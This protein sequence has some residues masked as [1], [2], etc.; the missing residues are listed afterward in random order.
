MRRQCLE[1]LRVALTH[2]LHEEIQPALLLPR[3]PI[4]RRLPL[5]HRR[6]Q[7]RLD[8]PVRPTASVLSQTSV[9]RRI[10][11]ATVFRLASRRA[12]GVQESNQVRNMTRLPR[13]R[14]QALLLVAGT[15]IASLPIAFG[16]IR[17]AQTGTDFR[18][19][20]SATAALVGAAAVTARGNI[21]DRVAVRGT[22]A[23][24][25]GTVLAAA[26]AVL[27]GARS[28]GAV[29]VVALAFGACAAMGSGLIAW[30]RTDRTDGVGA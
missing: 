5:P 20:W 24:C 10:L 22:L 18:Y 12:R 2:A 15:L 23:L 1:R 30:A 29:L 14:A 19:L 11:Y 17:A 7:Q 4:V 27:V 8:A 21:T 3:Y 28:P 25:M 13:S 9:S 16:V 6:M 26:T